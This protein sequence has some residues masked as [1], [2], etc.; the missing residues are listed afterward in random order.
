MI[1]RKFSNA[2][3]LT[4]GVIVV[5][6]AFEVERFCARYPHAIVC[7]EAHSPRPEFPHEPLAPADTPAHLTISQQE[8]ASSANTSTGS[9][10]ISAT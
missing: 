9:I 5:G 2:M 4:T 7:D 1:D 10:A 6:H 8:S 3:L